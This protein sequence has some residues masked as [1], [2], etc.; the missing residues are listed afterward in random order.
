MKKAQARLSSYLVQ[1]TTPL[2]SD[3][4]LAPDATNGGPLG[5]LYRGSQG[6]LLLSN[7]GVQEVPLTQNGQGRGLCPTSKRQ[8]PEFLG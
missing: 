8:P 5:F 4:R 2:A 6:P 1:N 3:P 7:S